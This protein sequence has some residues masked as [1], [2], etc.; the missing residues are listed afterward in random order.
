MAV[1][2]LPRNRLTGAE[3]AKADPDRAR[4]TPVLSAES[5][6]LDAELASASMWR[7]SS[8]SSRLV[9]RV[10]PRQ[11]RQQQGPVRDSLEPGRLTTPATLE[12]GVQTQRIHRLPVRSIKSPDRD[13]NSPRPPASSTVARP[14]E[15]AAWVRIGLKNRRQGSPRR[16]AMGRHAPTVAFGKKSSIKL[17]R[18]GP[19]PGAWRVVEA[20]AHATDDAVS[21]RASRPAASDSARNSFCPG[22]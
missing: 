16:L 5:F 12:N 2:A 14:R 7:M 3:T 22:P 18:P 17:T 10:V 21:L 20:G 9:S 15:R 11:G 1:P 8:L 19:L 4:C 6:V 13:V